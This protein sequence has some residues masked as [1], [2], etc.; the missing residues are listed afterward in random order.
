MLSEKLLAI[1]PE[2]SLNM[3]VQGNGYGNMNTPFRSHIVPT[4][5]ANFTEEK[6]GGRGGGLIHWRCVK[7]KKTLA[8][9]TQPDSSIQAVSL[10]SFIRV[11]KFSSW[12]TATSNILSSLHNWKCAYRKYIK[13][14]S[15]AS[16]PGI[17]RFSM[18]RAA[19]CLRR[20]LR[21][22][23]CGSLPV[24]TCSKRSKPRGTSLLALVI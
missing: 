23:C 16:H 21:M 19:F 18:G 12:P 17:G 7:G 4:E 13:I 24:E 20:L 14:I 5:S 11:P 8:N 3:S 2:T 9:F 10:L 22:F 15:H 6:G 1:V